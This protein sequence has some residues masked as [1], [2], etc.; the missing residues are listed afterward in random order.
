MTATVLTAGQHCA[1]RKSRRRLL[2]GTAANAAFMNTEAKE[3]RAFQ[4]E[5]NRCEMPDIAPGSRSKPNPKSEQ[6]SK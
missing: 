5:W 6:E 1:M 4:L 3:I 2:L